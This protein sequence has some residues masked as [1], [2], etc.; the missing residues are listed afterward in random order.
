[1]RRTWI[2]GLVLACACGSGTVDSVAEPLDVVFVHDVIRDGPGDPGFEAA[3]DQVEPHD[4]GDDVAVPDPGAVDDGPPDPGTQDPG[5][6]D[7]GGTDPGPTDP[8]PTDPGPIDAGFDVTI[9]ACAPD[10]TSCW[11]TADNHCNSAYNAT[12]EPNVCD[13]TTNHCRLDAQRLEGHACS[14][15]DTC[16]QGET[17]Q[18]GTCKGGTFTCQCRAAGDCDDQD[19]CTDDAC[20]SGTCRYTDNTAACDDGD[21]C[22]ANDACAAGTCQGTLVCQCRKDADCVDATPC[23]QDTCDLPTHTCIHAP[24]AAAC[25]DGDPCTT[26][27]A[28]SNGACAPGP[29]TCACRVAADC[30]DPGNPCLDRTCT[31]AHACVPTAN[32][33]ACDDGH[34][35]TTGDHCVGGACVSGVLTC[36]QCGDGGCWVPAE[37]CA[38]CP[39]DCGACP[40]VEATCGNGV[41]DDH[42]GQTDCQDLDCVGKS[43]CPQDTCSSKVVA[44]LQCGTTRTANY[45]NLRQVSG[46]GCGDDF[47]ALYSSVFQFVAPRTGT[48]QVQ[49]THEDSTGDQFHAYILSGVCNPAACAGRACCYDPG[50]TV[51][52]V[53]GMSYFIVV[54]DNNASS[55]GHYTLKVTCP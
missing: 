49:V 29:D 55:T 11:C 23:T 14:D 53:A 43:P 35:C 16:T 44:T 37:D 33:A 20:N 54:E 47:N 24:V 9:G 50:L 3:A 17:C 36:A 19:P 1:M 8:G 7:P 4:P 52:M 39:G 42:D 28:C 32:T 30:P 45:N 41:D 26:P 6:N 18:A 31:V 51:G 38:T 10:D 46:S 5:A 25:D 40:T 12:C 21:T 13:T 15:A 34:A 27:D 2:A 48:L 22:T